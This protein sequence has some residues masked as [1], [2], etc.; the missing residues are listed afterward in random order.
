MITSEMIFIV[1][2]ANFFQPIFKQDRSYNAFKQQQM[3]AVQKEIMPT[4]ERL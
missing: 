4:A 2:S 1:F 3:Q